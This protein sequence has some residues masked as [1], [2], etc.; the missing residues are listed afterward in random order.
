MKVLLIT[1]AHAPTERHSMCFRSLRAYCVNTVLMWNGSS[2]IK[3]LFAGLFIEAA[4]ARRSN[5]F[6][7]MM[8]VMN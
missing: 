7:A 2:W 1:A 5:A 3:H 6:M 4:A 8:T